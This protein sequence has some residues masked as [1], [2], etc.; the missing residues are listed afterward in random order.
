MHHTGEGCFFDRQSIG[1]LLPCPSH[2]TLTER[3]V[4]INRWTAAEGCDFRGEGR[5]RRFVAIFLTGIKQTEYVF[6]VNRAV[7]QVT[8]GKYFSKGWMKGKP[9]RQPDHHRVYRKGHLCL[10]KS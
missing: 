8:K 5:E 2:D 1:K 7:L 3:K 9:S 10:N 4:S 6:K